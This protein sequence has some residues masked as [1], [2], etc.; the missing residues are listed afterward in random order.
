V[1]ARHAN[2]SARTALV[3][4]LAT[5]RPP[6]KNPA[7]P[8]SLL[9]RP[10]YAPACP[11]DCLA[12]GAFMSTYGRW[13]SAAAIALCVD[14]SRRTLQSNGRRLR[15]HRLPDVRALDLVRCAVVRALSRDPQVQRALHL[16][17]LETAPCIRKEHSNTLLYI[18]DGGFVLRLIDGPAA[19][20][21]EP[22]SM[23]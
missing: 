10:L 22:M 9:P 14:C 17:E 21:F 1:V 23:R 16:G 19:L 8:Y 13:S 20:C 6:P 5:S 12:V 3:S 7:P 4:D 2:V 18:G 11:G 15:L